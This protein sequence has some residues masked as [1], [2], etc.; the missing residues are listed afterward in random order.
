MGWRNVIV[1]KEA[2]LSLR[3]EHLIVKT[4]KTIETPLLDIETLVIENPSSLITGHLLNALTDNK[5]TVILCGE[6]HNPK[7]NVLSLYGHH[8]QSKKIKE[9]IQWKN[10]EKYYL[11][12]R[13][14]QEKLNNQKRVLEETGNINRIYLLE[15][16]I[17][18]VEFDDSTNREGHG[19]K[20][21][22]NE[23][24]GNEFNR[25]KECYW[26][27]GLNYGY[28]VLLAIFNRVLVSK[29]ILLELGIKHSNEF[30]FYNLSCD[31]IE[32]FR[33]IVDYEVR[34]K[35]KEKFEIEERLMLASITEKQVKIKK[36]VYYLNNAIDIY[37]DSLLKY[38]KDGD[39]KDLE[40]PELIFK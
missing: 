20:V 33:P 39:P 16:Y 30:N 25:N 7:T 34:T 32:P 17:R 10:G 37:C 23:L 38:L 14:V 26:N 15:E 24:F 4:E 3:M 29:G 8:R 12:K 18:D 19:A 13:I 40:F 9:Q 22:F 31:F 35:I 5:I 21:Y 27:W 36:Q 6:N 1:T 11:W 28:S 2:K